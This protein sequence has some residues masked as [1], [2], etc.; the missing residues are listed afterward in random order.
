V[1]ARLILAALLLLSVF[2]LT[3][4][5]LYSA[6]RI[7]AIN[8]YHVAFYIPTSSYEYNTYYY[9]Q[10][11]SQVDSIFIQHAY[12]DTTYNYEE[13]Y[14]F[15]YAEDCSGPLHQRL[16]TRYHNHS[17]VRDYRYWIFTDALNRLVFYKQLQYDD[18]GNPGS[19]KEYTISYTATSKPDTI[20]YGVDRATYYKFEYIYDSGDKLQTVFVYS[21]DDITGS[22]QPLLRFNHYYT[23]GLN[24]IQ[25]RMKMLEYPIYSI[26]DFIDPALY[27]DCEY[28]S[29]YTNVH[30]WVN[31]QW[32][33]F[34]Y[35]ATYFFELD[36]HVSGLQYVYSMHSNYI[37]PTLYQC[38]EE[39]TFSY[40]GDYIGYYRPWSDTADGYSVTW[41]NYVPNEDDAM[42]VPQPD[43]FLSAYPNPF[44]N[45]LNIIIDNRKA[46]CN[47]SVYNIRG[48]LIRSWKDIRAGELTWDGK[49]NANNSVSSGIYF[50]KAQTSGHISVVKAVKY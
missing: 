36:A 6:S 9:S 21:Y 5:P 4:V 2:W 3:E 42:P 16:Y 44:I 15:D 13:V 17:A 31:N 8:K 48:Q 30:R 50:I 22:S 41:E 43:N 38:F 28:I 33:G 18:Q 12:E 46:A 27:F 32:V 20:Y 34:P 7:H 26:T 19:S 11:P 47:L 24:P 40:G 10:N 35:P 49:D 1:T 23:P 25:F 14:T 29:D 37:L 45:N 39:Y